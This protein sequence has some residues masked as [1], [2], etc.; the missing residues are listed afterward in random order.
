M[1]D[2]GNKN[3]DE[4]GPW[5]RFA[6]SVVIVAIATL[7]LFQ[8]TLA[9][10]LWLRSTLCVLVSAVTSTWVIW[11]HDWGRSSQGA[12]SG[13]GV[14]GALGAFLALMTVTFVTSV[15]TVALFYYI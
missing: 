3:P 4:M 11:R 10:P 1:T 12:E 13:P 9:V 15:V 5:P 8:P 6:L 7:V 14:W 2:R